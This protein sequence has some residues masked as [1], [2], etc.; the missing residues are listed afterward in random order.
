MIGIYIKS[1]SD[2]AERRPIV[3]MLSHRLKRPIRDDELVAFSPTSAG[4]SVA[5]GHVCSLHFAAPEPRFEAVALS[6]RLRL[7]ANAWTQNLIRQMNA[8]IQPGGH[9]WLP[10]TPE[11]S[12]GLMND[13]WLA[14]W[15]GRPR[16]KRVRGEWLRLD[17]RP[18][19]AAPPSTLSWFFEEDLADAMAAELTT[20]PHRS[21]PDSAN[22]TTSNTTTLAERYLQQMNYSI[23]GASYK[24]ALVAHITGTCLPQREGMTLVDV[25][26]GRGLVAF[27]L[28]LTLPAF[29]RAVVCDPLA[30]NVQRVERT[31]RHFGELIGDR[32][33][34]IV[35]TAEDHEFR[36]E[37]DVITFIGSL[38]YVSRT[39][40]S[41][42]LSRAWQSLRPGGL[43]IVHENIKNPSYQ[44]DYDVMFTVEEIDELLERVGP[45]RR[46]LSTATRE[47]SKEAAKETS[48]FR[49]VQKA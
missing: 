28:L 13:R 48:V 46:F 32:F 36:H 6:P 39:H 24:S 10:S 37:A 20:Q 41:D 35:T 38:L 17:R 8:S 5:G 31:R 22:G 23:H 7:F 33:E 45:V 43:L 29:E 21:N 42:V 12:D 40:T 14:A 25:G 34:L 3:E 18:Q 26:G 44:K 49:V 19:I 27:E 11:K 2:D 9:L 47:V 15:L 1:H 30:T 16:A 4:A